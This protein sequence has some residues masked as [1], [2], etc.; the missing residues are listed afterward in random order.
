LAT[1]LDEKLNFG[2]KSIVICIPA[3]NEEKNIA[4]LIID[5]KKYTDKIIVI[6]DGSTDYTP[7]I[8]R[9]L[10]VN[11]IQH[12]KNLGKGA[13]LRTAFKN[14]M[15]YSP[16]VVVT[17]DGDG[18]HDPSFIPKLIEPVLSGK[19]DVVIGSRSDKTKMPTYRKI[20]LKTIN[21]LNKKAIKS[22]INDAQSGFRAY[23][24]K[25]INALAQERY[26]DYSAEFE[27]LNSLI[28]KGF[29]ISEVPVE[30]KYEGLEKTSKKNFLTHGGEL[31]LASLFMIVSKRPIL[32]LTLPG[33]IFLI[34]GLI[35]AFNTLF[36]F[37]DLRYF[38]IPMSIISA[39]LLILGTL[40]VLSS[41]FIYII[42]KMQNSLR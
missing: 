39:S 38:S 5:A 32:Y 30:I 1:S 17:M 14:A 37:N 4:R 21:Y 18:Q 13:A 8:S 20:G 42:S 25:S 23:S 19:S 41:M 24:K 26:Q 6:D 9:E 28:Q 7:I 27:Q 34:V 40:F 12:E 22:K 35:F 33:S 31:I 16:D 10:G 36:L 15:T 29:Q 2:K 3:F 11:L